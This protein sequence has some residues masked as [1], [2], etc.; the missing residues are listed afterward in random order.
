MKTNE[1]RPLFRVLSFIIALLMWLVCG[2]SL[3]SVLEN[4]SGEYQN[5]ELVI[6]M[7]IGAVSFSYVAIAGYMPKTLLMQFSRGSV[8]DDK[9]LK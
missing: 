4:G 1:A 3:V 9:Y 5:W 8:A 6:G 7:L 2:S